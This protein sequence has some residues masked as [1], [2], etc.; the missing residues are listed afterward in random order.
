MHLFFTVRL[1]ELKSDVVLESLYCESFV[2]YPT[3]RGNIHSSTAIM[4]CAVMDV[5][6]PLYKNDPTYYHLYP[7]SSRL[8]RKGKLTMVCFSFKGFS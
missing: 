1:A 4:S 7:Y 5:L 8:L 3:T 6:A 2:L